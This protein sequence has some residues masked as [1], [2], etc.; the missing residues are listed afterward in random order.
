MAVAVH[1]PLGGLHPVLG[2]V[3]HPL[4]LQ[5]VHRRILG[6][7][8]AE[9]AHAH[10]LRRV[11]AE[12][13]TEGTVHL[14]QAAVGPDQQGSEQ[15]ALEARGE[16]LLPRP[17]GVPGALAVDRGGEEVGDALDD[18]GVLPVEGLGTPGEGRDHPPHPAVGTHPGAQRA[19]K[20]PPPEDDVVADHGP[21]ELARGPHLGAEDGLVVHAPQFVNRHAV[22]VE[23][24]RDRRRNEWDAFR[25]PAT[26]GARG[27]RGQSAREGD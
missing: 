13:L 27:P 24:P 22:G 6:R 15:R 4:E 19:A 2:E 23:S 25:R 17:V 14:Q 20:A 10:E 8:D 21:A 7:G 3:E 1:E 11:A 26:R 12:H 18:E 5:R 16:A 9:E